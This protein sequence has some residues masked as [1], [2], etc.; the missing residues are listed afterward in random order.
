MPTTTTKLIREQQQTL[1]AALAPNRM[2]DVDFREYKDE[3]DFRDWAEAHPTAALRKFYIE[4]VGPYELPT[5]SD[6]LDEEVITNFEVLVAYPKNGRYSTRGNREEMIDVM[7]KDMHDIDT[8]IGLR[9]GAN[10]VS[11]QN[12]ALAVDKIIE[13]G[14][15]V[16]FLLFNYE[17]NFRRDMS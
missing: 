11:G 16:D 14:E 7:T 1:I 12:A 13:P 8:A 3:E 6:T 2:S 17:I 5:I 9:G 10:Y 4:D 15:V